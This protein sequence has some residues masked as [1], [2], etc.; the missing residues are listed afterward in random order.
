MNDNNRSYSKE[1]LSCSFCGKTH[2]QV[3]KLVTGLTGHICNVCIELCHK[4]M[5]T[6]QDIKKK[7]F[8]I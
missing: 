5:M 4:M 7:M 3:L 1:T 8:L 2:D 6:S